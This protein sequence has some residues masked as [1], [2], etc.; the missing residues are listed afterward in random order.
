MVIYINCVEFPLKVEPILCFLG[1][2][3][4]YPHQVSIRVYF[5]LNRDICGFFYFNHLKTT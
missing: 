5:G 4:F 2:R 1:Y 3:G